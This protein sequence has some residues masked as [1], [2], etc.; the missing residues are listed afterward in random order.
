M[1][2]KKI[3]HLSP[4]QNKPILEFLF[5]VRTHQRPFIIPQFTEMGIKRNK[6]NH[7]KNR[8]NSNSMKQAI[9]KV[10]RIAL[11]IITVLNCSLLQSQVVLPLI[12]ELQNQV[13]QRRWTAQRRRFWIAHIRNWRPRICNSVSKP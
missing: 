8:E 13:S 10:K 12:L 9:I 11:K 1:N 7:H 2:K 4:I 5:L 3:P 6:K